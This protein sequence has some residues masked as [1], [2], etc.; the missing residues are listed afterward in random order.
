MWMALIMLH[1]KPRT[2]RTGLLLCGNTM[3]SDIVKLYTRQTIYEY[4]M[5][6]Y[7]HPNKEGGIN[8]K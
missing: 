4:W 2:N 5:T 1:V 7:L 8:A 3:F 6:Y